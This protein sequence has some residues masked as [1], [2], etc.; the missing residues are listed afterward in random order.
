V[1]NVISDILGNR[2]DFSILM[3]DIIRVLSLYFGQLWLS[4]LILELKGFRASLGDNQAIDEDEF[5]R[6]IDKLRTYNVINVEERLRSSLLSGSVP[7]KM[8]KLIN[9][10]EVYNAVKDDE[11]YVKYIKLRESILEELKR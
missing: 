4:E 7:D 9:L 5:E 11:R 1:A 6:A 3:G 2:D 10:E 8:V